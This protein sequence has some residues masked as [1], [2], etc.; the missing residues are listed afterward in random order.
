MMAFLFTVEKMIMPRA[1]AER[2]IEYIRKQGADSVSIPW[3][4]FYKIIHRERIH[5]AFEVR[6]IRELKNQSFLFAKGSAVIV[7]S[8][9]FNFCEL[10]QG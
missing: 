7:I 2:I 6:L 1:A 3:A 8:K 9:D 5:D 10:K 4:K